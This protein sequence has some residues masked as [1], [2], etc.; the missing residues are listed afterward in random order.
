MLHELFVEPQM[1]IGGFD[2]RDLIFLIVDGEVGA[3]KPGRMG[4][5][6]TVA[7]QRRTQNEWN[8]NTF[9][10]AESSAPSSSEATRL[11]ISSAALLV[12]VT[13][14]TAEGGTRS[15]CTMRATRCVM[16][17]VSAPG[18]G[19]DQQRAFRFGDGFALLGIHP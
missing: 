13:A 8:V 4:Q 7:P 19:Q 12:K 2:Q 11:R 16:T 18:A 5:G 14:S 3:L 1:A 15:S 9:G 6:L 10:A 17:R